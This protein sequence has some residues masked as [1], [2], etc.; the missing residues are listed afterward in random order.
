MCTITEISLPP[1]DGYMTKCCHSSRI[2]TWKEDKLIKS[3][4]IKCGKNNPKL[5]PYG[6]TKK[7]E[8]KS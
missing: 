4:C 3:S 2:T 8:G 7:K 1:F 5:I 6:A